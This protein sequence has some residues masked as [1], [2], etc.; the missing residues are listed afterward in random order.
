MTLPPWIKDAWK[1][2]M[3]EKADNAA[4]ADFEPWSLTFRR[5]RPITVAF[6]DGK[7]QLTI[8]VANLKSG[9]DV[10]DRWDVTATYS[11]EMADGGVTLTPRRRARRA[12]DRLRSRRKGSSRRGKSPCDAT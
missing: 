7:V 10:F 11:P 8:H 4:D 3:D 12:A 2:R 6:V 1:N 9:D 5:D